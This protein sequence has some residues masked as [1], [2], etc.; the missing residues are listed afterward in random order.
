LNIAI[1]DEEGNEMPMRRVIA[2]LVIVSCASVGSTRAQYCNP[3]VVG[4]IVHDQDGKLLGATELR[5][6]CEQLPE[7][8][9][10]A[11]TDTGEVSFA[12][13]GRTF[14]WPESVDWDKGRKVPVL[15]FINSE[16]CTL[17]L[18]EVT[19]VYHQER[20]R[21]IFNVDI[22]RSQPDRRPVVDSPPFQEGTFELDLSGWTHEEHQM[23]PSSMWRK[24]NDN[25]H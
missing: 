24:V 13:D 22:E 6:I 7:S 23:I 20:M 5:A 19:L 15:Q 14:Y 12:D 18:A 4:Y 25:A 1:W 3:A 21:L 9:G 8:I 11:H 10:D 16:T 17:H 2:V